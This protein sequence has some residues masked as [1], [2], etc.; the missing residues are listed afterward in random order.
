M[1]NKTI[2]RRSFM[3]ASASISGL[4]V[5]AAG[6]PLSNALLNSG[7]LEAQKAH[8]VT[9]LDKYT[10]HTRHVKAEYI[11]MFANRFAEIYGVVD[12]KAYFS[13]PIGEHRL[14]TLFLKS[15]FRPNK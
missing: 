12:Y 1:L 10:G 3:T 9:V 8:M 4:A 14:V 6:V 7:T 13:G 11:Q 2:S 5:L 15:V